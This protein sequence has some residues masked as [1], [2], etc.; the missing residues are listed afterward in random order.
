MQRVLCYSLCP[1][2][3]RTGHRLGG[4]LSESVGGS[5][6]FGGDRSAVFLLGRL[7]MAERGH[8]T[9]RPAFLATGAK[10]LRDRR[11]REDISARRAAL[12]RSKPI[13]DPLGFGDILFL[14]AFYCSVAV[15]LELR[16]R[17]GLATQPGSA[18]GAPLTA[19]E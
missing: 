10:H 16:K 18:H 19:T 4:D 2:R 11:A 13:Y 9:S 1:L 14:A 8:A 12:R 7:C 6:R 17:P 3:Q 5:A 15:I